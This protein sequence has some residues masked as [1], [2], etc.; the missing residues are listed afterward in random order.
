MSKKLNSMPDF[1]A[2]MPKT[3]H[4]VSQSTAFTTCPGMLSPVY[5]DMLHTGD[6]LHFSAS[7]F[8]RLNPLESQPLGQ[9]DVHLDYFFVPLTVMYTPASSMFY[10]TDDLI[11]SAIDKTQFNDS[12]VFPVF[13]FSNY[14]DYLN[15]NANSLQLAPSYLGTGLPLWH[16]S[17]DW[18]LKSVYRIWDLL[19]MSPTCL[20]DA[21]GGLRD[22]N[23]SS[24]DAYY[25]SFT[26]WFALA[27][28]AIYQLYFRNDD[29]EPKNYH[30]NI[31]QY[32]NIG[33]FSESN[34]NMKSIFN[35]NYCNRPK[36]YFESA[37]VNPLTSTVSAL[38]PNVLPSIYANVNNWLSNNA[39]NAYEDNAV[40]DS[41]IGPLSTQMGKSLYNHN[42]LSPTDIRQV[43]MVDKLIRVIGRAEKNYESQF[44]AHF[45]IKIPHDS[46]H[47]ITHIGHDMVTLTPD[48]VI[49]TANT[50]D[51]GNNT[52]SA[53]GEIGGQGKVMLS[54]RKHSFEAPFH[55]VFM[56]ISHIVP[57]RRYVVGLNKLHYLNGV[58]S[59]WQPEFDKMGMQPIF[60]SEA[61]FDIDNSDTS[62]RVGWQ[63]GYEQFKRK[64]D[65]V[66]SAF[67]PNHTNIS[68]NKY[69][70]WVISNV[71]YCNLNSLG[72]TDSS[73]FGSNTVIPYLMAPT[74]M[75]VNMQVPYSPLWT[76][77]AVSKETHD[78]HKPWLIYQTDPFICDFNLYCKKVN[79]MST[80][81]EPEL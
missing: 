4:D 19:D 29:R 47:N 46:M 7:E 1:T 77:S 59:F 21:L 70:P 13:G 11:S 52:G 34:Y 80:Y 31:D 2:H 18:Y 14:L 64:Y 8:V 28:Q 33:F 27:Y 30:F 22:S 38:N 45:G 68:V 67:T 78:Q 23:S 54:G 60:G 61:L 17:Y 35:M 41:S 24:I 74:D 12:T 65:R 49:S 66:T 53:L 25:P 36:D 3:A 16:S 69:A 48:S 57:R 55:G 44:L 71:P 79:G 58:N 15:Q 56:C 5:F 9:I 37:K 75:N 32:Y 51:S 42:I 62:L 63:F 72:L 43:F 20:L 50:Y 76:N 39:V 73:W 26:P 6:K 81:S 40:Q 10:Q